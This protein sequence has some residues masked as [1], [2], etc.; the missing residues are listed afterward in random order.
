MGLGVYRDP[1][2]WFD[3]GG[4][5]ANPGT[6]IGL[7]SRKENNAGNSA[8]VCRVKEAISFLKVTASG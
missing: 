4:S 3:V 1:I 5:G 6:C 7:V 8:G 2:C